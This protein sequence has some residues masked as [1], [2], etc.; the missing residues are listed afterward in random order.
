MTSVPSAASNNYQEDQA[1]YASSVLGRMIKE[2]TAEEA[3]SDRRDSDRGARAKKECLEMSNQALSSLVRESL[4]FC[5]SPQK[6]PLQRQ[7]RHVAGAAADIPELI[8]EPHIIGSIISQAHPS[9]PIIIMQRQSHKQEPAADDDVPPP[10]RSLEIAEQARIRAAEQD[11]PFAALGASV[12]REKR[13]YQFKSHVE[14]FYLRF[15]EPTGAIS[16]RHIPRDI[17]Q[18]IEEPEQEMLAAISKQSSVIIDSL[19]KIVS[20]FI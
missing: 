17:T 14:H 9:K 5:G 16:Y 8:S 10:Y 11:Q 3:G 19:G 2:A 20:N 12:E 18:I 1:V 15:G 6:N 13:E 7:Q 4:T